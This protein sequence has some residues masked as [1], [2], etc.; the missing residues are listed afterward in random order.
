MHEITLAHVETAIRTMAETALANEQYFS[1]LDGAC[2]DGDFGTS[3]AT[4]FRKVLE[5]WDTLD[6]SS[7][8]GLLMK[9]GMIITSNV[10]GCSGPIWG[11][12][13]LR[14]ATVARGKTTLALADLVAMAGAAM[15]GMMARG[16]A[17]LGDKTLLDALAPAAQK[18]AAAAAQGPDV[19]AAWD[20]ATAAATAAIEG[21]R[22]L[23]ARRG[24]QSFTGDRSQGTLD[25]GIVGVATMMHAIGAALKKTE[26]P[27]N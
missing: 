17:Q 24:R 27:E 25:P 3:L 12:G 20:E 4:G 11:T 16:G 23:T 14:A 22:H 10:G 8:A 21:T 18:L 15:T 26:R 1:E 13:F 7:I 2:G 9:T 6:R 19:L 5:E